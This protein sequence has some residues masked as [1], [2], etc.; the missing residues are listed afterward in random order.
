MVWKVDIWRIVVA[1]ALSAIVAIGLYSGHTN[2]LFMLVNLAVLYDAIYL[3]QARINKYVVAI[4]FITMIGFNYR[5]LSLYNCNQYLTI[6]IILVTQVSDVYQYVCGA[7]FGKNK[8]G[9]VSKNKTYEGYIGGLICTIM[10][11]G[12]FYSVI[13]VM[14]IYL[15]GIIGGLCSS[16]FKRMIGVKDYS[17][18]LG[19][20]GGWCD[21]ADSILLPTLISF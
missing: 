2:I 3:W 15:A 21:R 19:D 13:D 5:L 8:I 14:I 16:I 11:F 10:T 7:R 17:N 6:K 12:W 9:W 4:L 1:L 20:H 18:L